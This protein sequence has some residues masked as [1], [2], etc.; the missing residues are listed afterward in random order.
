MVRLLA[1]ATDF[2]LLQSTE[3]SSGA[4]TF[5]HWISNRGP[6]SVAKQLG[7]WSW[8]LTSIY[9]QGQEC[10]KVHNHSLYMPSQHTTLPSPLLCTVKVFQVEGSNSKWGLV[11]GVDRDLCYLFPKIFTNYGLFWTLSRNAWFQ[12]IFSVDQAWVTPLTRFCHVSVPVILNET[13]HDI[14]NPSK[15]ILGEYS[16]HA[17]TYMHIHSPTA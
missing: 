1:G 2:S 9:C 12:F 4:H 11:R 10:V 5:S 14:F 17:T 7:V 15:E 3:T 8:S 16:N 13:S 6:F